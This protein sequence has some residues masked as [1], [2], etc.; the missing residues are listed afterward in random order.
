MLQQLDHAAVSSH[1]RHVLAVPSARRLR[2]LLAGLA[3]GITVVG[4]VSV[5]LEQASGYAPSPAYEGTIF[6]L[7]S[8][9]RSAIPPSARSDLAS[10]PMVS[11]VD[12]SGENHIVNVGLFGQAVYEASPQT[13]RVRVGVTNAPAWGDNDLLH[14]TV[15]IPVDA[16][17]STGSDSKL[18]IVDRLAR[19]VYDLWY[20][21]RDSTGWTAGW[22]GVY[23]IDGD[24]LSHNVTYGAGPDRVPYPHPLTRA[25]GSGISSLLGLATVDELAR[26]RIDHA[27]VF[28][29]RFAC[30]PADTGPFRF[31]ATTTDGYDLSPA[32]IPEGTRVQLDPSIDLA[33]LPG[34]APF[35]VTVGRALQRYGA[36]LVDN[37]GAAVAIVA[38]NPRSAGDRALL[39]AQGISDGYNGAN[40]L[41][42]GRLRILASDGG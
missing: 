28:S 5:G 26:G 7:A 11:R 19:K 17:P 30:G 24:G 3:V 8:G 6:P 35:E 41:P 13:P 21:R 15:P 32:C 4:G 34:I 25:T 29:S 36:Y 23:A 14:T 40:H 27:L 9:F 18:V 31:P 2:H 22:G 37:G 33:S 10:G 38:E 20:A 12:A 39:L 1:T 42:W 16:R